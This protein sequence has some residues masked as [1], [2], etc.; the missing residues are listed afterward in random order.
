MDLARIIHKSRSEVSEIPV[1]ARKTTEQAA[2]VLEDTLRIGGGYDAASADR[3]G[4]AVDV[5]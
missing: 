5:L 1:M 3:S 2:G 4:H